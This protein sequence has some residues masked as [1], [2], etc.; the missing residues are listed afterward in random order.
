MRTAGFTVSSHSAHG[1]SEAYDPGHPL[2]F[3]QSGF[4]NRVANSA[5]FPVR[6][7]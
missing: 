6:L 2:A 3:E 5:S 1:F 4:T 7:W